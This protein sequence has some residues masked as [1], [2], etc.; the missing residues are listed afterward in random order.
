MLVCC[1]GTI[2]LIQFGA[3]LVH[4]FS[5]MTQIL[6]NTKLTWPN[7]LF[8]WFTPNRD[9]VSTHKQL[10]EK[11]AVDFIK[12]NMNLFDQ[13]SDGSNS[14]NK[15]ANRKTIQKLWKKRTNKKEFRD[16]EDVFNENIR[17][18]GKLQSN[19]NLARKSQ[20]IIVEKLY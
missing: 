4:R 9:V 3:M 19:G 10:S 20:N 2:L 1:F 18:I 6:A 17:K 8:N 7:K 12:H 14:S 5:T 15:L 11:N 13:N 16:L